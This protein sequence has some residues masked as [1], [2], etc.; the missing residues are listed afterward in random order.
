MSRL[1][2]VPASFRDSGGFLY[3]RDG[4]L[5]RQINQSYRAHYEQ[6]IQSGLYE[7]LVKQGLLVDHT[8]CDISL[9]KSD[10]AYKVILPKRLHYISYP[11]EWCF[12]QIKDAALL[13]LRIQKLA[14]EHGMILKDASAYNVQFFHGRPVFIDTLSFEIYKSGPWIAYRQFCQHFFA[15]LCMLAYTDHRLS[16]LY[17][18]YIDGPP[19][20]LV[21]KLLPFKTWFKYSIL[22]HIHIHARAQ[23]HY[24]KSADEHHKGDKGRLALKISKNQITA[25]ASQM[26]SAI[27]KLKFGTSDTEWSDYYSDTNYSNTSLDHKKKLVKEYIAS[28]SPS[29]V[30]I[31]DIGA[32]DG[33]FSR[34]AAGSGAC[35]ISQ[36]IDE[37]AVEK[38]YI[39]CIKNN[40]KQI[41]P[42][43]LDL[44][45][46]SPALGWANEERDSALKRS[47]CNVLMALALIHH[48]AI[49]N[50]VPLEKISYLFSRLC[51]YL[52][53]EFVPKQDS[54][55]TRLLATRE[56]IFPEYNFEGFELAFEQFFITERC[57]AI[58]GTERKLYLMRIRPDLGARP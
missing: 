51:D 57:E 26:E 10:L 3:E 41:L 54:Q 28:V 7:A 55:V 15:P 23:K 43:L 18:V 29:P 11:Y 38:N 17:R 56:D 6:L 39:R 2:D 24:S 20:D 31:Q 13:T 32:N 49:S 27:K 16:K 48:I 35:V 33:S 5:Y 37:V 36:D 21:S 46:P 53:I 8:E 47:K 30:L 42:L 34:I 22:A 4:I 9:A 19:L 1:I 44:T 12:S 40:D 58:S 52:I 25:I 14:L 45:N 50:N